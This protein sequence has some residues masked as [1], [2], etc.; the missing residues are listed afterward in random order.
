MNWLRSFATLLA[1]LL[2]V[3]ISAAYADGISGTRGDGDRNADLTSR[4]T[5]MADVNAHSF[6][7]IAHEPINGIRDG[8]M[9]RVALWQ[10]HNDADT[11]TSTPMPTPEQPTLLLLMAGVSAVFF[12]RRRVMQS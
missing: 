9:M 12:L 4:A 1:L 8:Y 11:S 3:G 2:V 6:G 5:P 10:S 7:A